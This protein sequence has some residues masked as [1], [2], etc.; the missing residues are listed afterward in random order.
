[1]ALVSQGNGRVGS[2]EWLDRN[3]MCRTLPNRETAK[4]R[5][6]ASED[7]ALRLGNFAPKGPHVAKTPALS[8]KQK[9]ECWVHAV[10][11]GEKKR[12]PVAV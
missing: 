1:M 12:I 2:N 7:G 6:T 9:L 5:H 8:L 10:N 3:F 4:R 11:L